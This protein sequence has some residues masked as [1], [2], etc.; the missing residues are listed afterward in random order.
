VKERPIIF[1]PESVRGLL[2]GTK[3]MTRRVVKTLPGGLV[4]V[5]GGS[6]I[7][8]T[9]AGLVWNPYGGSP[10]VPWPAERLHEVA[11]YYAVGDRLWVRETFCRA[12]GEI[13]YRA[14]VDASH[15]AEERRVRRLAPEIAVAYRE[16]RWRSPLLM[17]RWA[18]RLTL[19]ITSVRVERLRD[20]TPED[21]EAEGIEIPSHHRGS[22]HSPERWKFDH[23][24]SRGYSWE[25]NPFVWVI[26]LRRLE[27]AEAA[28]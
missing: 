18:S 15:L 7:R 28:A 19:E 27:P 22:L 8:L 10:D 26:G 3:T 16:S 14:D 4:R 1:G 20:I 24:A 2:A 13:L 6:A 21:V 17:L 12:D 11:P 23:Y 25:S 9:D 5:R